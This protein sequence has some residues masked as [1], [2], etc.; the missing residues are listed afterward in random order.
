M[1]VGVLCA[2]ITKDES[3]QPHVDVDLAAFENQFKV[4]VS[5]TK[6]MEES[7]KERIKV[8]EEEYAKM[9]A[10][11]VRYRFGGWAYH[12]FPSLQIRESI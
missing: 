10:E 4:I 3:L 9:T 1:L 12:P 7:S 8:L 5:E 2:E 6:K 11:K